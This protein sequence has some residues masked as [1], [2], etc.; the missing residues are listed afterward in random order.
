[1]PA[2]NDLVRTSCRMCGKPIVWLRTA[3]GKHS[4]C[5]PQTVRGFDADG[6]VHEVRES[7][8][9]YC[10]GVDASRRRIEERREVQA[11]IAPPKPEADDGK[12]PLVF[13]ARKPPVPDRPAQLFAT[14]IPPIDS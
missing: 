3:G 12:S 4:P 2:G 6:A 13:G 7:H 9:A 8:F 5:E 11:G 14:D 10:R 1:M